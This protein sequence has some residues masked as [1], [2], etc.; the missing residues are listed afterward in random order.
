[1]SLVY[2]YEK[3]TDFLRKENRFSPK[4][5]FNKEKIFSL[6]FPL[7]GVHGYL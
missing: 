3:R 5:L 4:I 6:E 7:K 2:R 1:M